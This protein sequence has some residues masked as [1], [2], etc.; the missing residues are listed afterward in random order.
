MR[1]QFCQLT[2][3]L[4]ASVGLVAMAVGLLAFASTALASDP[5][6]VPVPIERCDDCP[7]DDFC[8]GNKCKDADHAGCYD[9]FE[10]LLECHECTCEFD[11]RLGCFCTVV[12]PTP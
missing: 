8:R 11:G 5:I 2:S 9:L 4:F 3:A 10:K 12:D 6:Q 1:S 7:Y